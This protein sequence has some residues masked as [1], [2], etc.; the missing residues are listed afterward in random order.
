MTGVYIYDILSIMN[1]HPG[2]IINNL[3]KI[4]PKNTV[5]LYPWLLKQGV[6]RQL[7]D[8]YVRSGWLEKVGR[9]AF[10]KAGDKI[11][12][13]GALYSLQSYLN[14][15]V[16][17]AGKTALQLLGYAHF[18]PVNLEQTKLVLFGTKHEKLP[19][20]FKNNMNFQQ[21]GLRYT[22][23]ELFSK[24][25]S[26]GLT[27]FQSGD[28]SIMISSAER[29]ALEF[30]YDV[31]INESYAELDQIVAGLNTLRPLTVQ[32]L[33]ENCRSIKAK[34]LFMH[35]SEKHR[36]AWIKNIDLAKV[37]FGKGKRSLCKNGRYYSKYQLVVPE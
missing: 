21:T 1:G 29:A 16:H 30:C 15:T 37:D 31:P 22:A 18:I 9:G 23:T 12:W 7:S 32:S 34:R 14:L 20:W 24:D 10:K 26:A 19:A 35:L 25:S 3:L 8:Q 33:M 27:A 13:H 11:E 36:H 6:Y 28:F 17:P 4:W 5:A 2:G